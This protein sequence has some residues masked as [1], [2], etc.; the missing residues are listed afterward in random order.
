MNKKS[1]LM[2]SSSRFVPKC[3]LLHVFRYVSVP[4]RM[5]S[6]FLPLS[7][8]D[9]ARAIGVCTRER[10]QEEAK[11]STR[12]PVYLADILKH[13]DRLI[14]SLLAGKNTS[15]LFLLLALRVQ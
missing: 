2:L 5:L 6:S 1:L 12:S 14:K 11:I 7:A 9:A 4:Y 8:S 15:N 3:S 10:D 13:S